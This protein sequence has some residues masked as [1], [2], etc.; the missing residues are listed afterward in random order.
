MEPPAIEPR[1]VI[2]VADDDRDVRT[3]VSVA[4]EMGGY[5]VRTAADGQ[6]A[7]DALAS[8]PADLIVLDLNMPGMD[9]WTFCAERARR[10]TLAGV[11]VVLMSARYQLTDRTLPC[12]PIG[13][14]E[15]P[16]PL[17]ILLRIVA[18]AVS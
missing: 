6:T 7:L 16:F 13:V 12:N 4:L 5:S 11:P 8:Q 14:L 3:F 1:P 9:G 18:D 2:L 15:K 17:E 10:P